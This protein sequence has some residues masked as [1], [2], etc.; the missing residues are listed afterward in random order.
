M[1][2]FHLM[3]KPLGGGKT[4]KIALQRKSDFI[5]DHFHRFPSFHEASKDPRVLEAF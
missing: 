5:G 1:N 4:G 2:G 3:H